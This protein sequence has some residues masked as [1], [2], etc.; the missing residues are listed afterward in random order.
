MKSRA[1]SSGVGITPSPDRHT[2]RPFAVF[3]QTITIDDTVR[4]FQMAPT[5]RSLTAFGTISVN[6]VV[7]EISGFRI[8][9]T[10]ISATYVEKTRI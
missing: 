1:R 4:D 6:D 10:A 9:P 7:I 8:S 2:Q 3:G 5:S